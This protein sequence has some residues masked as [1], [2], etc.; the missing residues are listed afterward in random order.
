MISINRHKYTNL[1][2]ELLSY[3]TELFH[4]VSLSY[5]SIPYQ[6]LEWLIGFLPAQLTRN[7]HMV[8]KKQEKER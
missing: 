3:T 7:H 4:Q 2:I 6:L 8:M 5:Y 1:H